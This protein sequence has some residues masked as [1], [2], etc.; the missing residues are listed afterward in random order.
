M[1]KKVGILT[2][3]LR[4]YNYGGILQNFALQQFL[5]KNFQVEVET[6]DIDYSNS[7]G[8]LKA[9]IK[10]ALFK[11]LYFD[12]KA[13]RSKVNKHLENFI[14]K[15]IKLTETIY[16]VAELENLIEKKGFHTIITGS[17]Q[18]WRLKYLNSNLEKLLF[19]D[20]QKKSTLKIAYA[21]SFGVD[22][23]EDISASKR[24]KSYL[25]VF[26]AISVREKSGVKICEQNFGI[27]VQHLIDP[28]LL[29]S[30]DD[31]IGLMN[32][33]KG[34][35]NRKPVFFSYVL[36]QS[37]EKQTLIKELQ[38]KMGTESYQIELLNDKLGSI[39]KS[40]YKS[41]KNSKATPVEDWL[42][43]FYEADY[44]IT[45]SF[46]GMVF[47]I[48]FNK[49]FLVW[50]NESRGLTRFHSLLDKLDLRD[51]IIDSSSLDEIQKA[52]KSPIDY[53]KVNEVLQS[54]REKSYQFFKKH[55]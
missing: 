18:V 5:E 10:S 48:L 7:K 43:R 33:Q 54:E 9:Q 46:H 38:L 41:L 15:H 12:L 45:D 16:T 25:S 42:H 20:F 32:K 52:L 35:Q 14:Q 37:V 22:E 28:T 39:N 29:L 55:L 49:K 11:F 44:V 51:R 21:A 3:P 1:K 13:I 40:N 2:L 30:V 50:G 34:M 53:V 26:N 19:L 31:Y 24:I 4:N 47:S 6:I 27:N 17:D 8:N 36:D 23:L